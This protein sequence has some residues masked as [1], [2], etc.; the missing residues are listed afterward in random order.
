MNLERLLNRLPKTGAMVAGLLMIVGLGILDYVTGPE[1]TFGIFYV[2]PI[3]LAAWVAGKRGGIFLSV[4]AGAAWLIADVMPGHYS[5]PAIAY[6]NAVARLGFFLAISVL[7]SSLRAKK[8][9]LEAAVS[10]KTASLRAE[11]AEHKHTAEALRESEQRLRLT[12]ESARD[13]AVFRLDSEGRVVGWNAGA[14]RLLGYSENEVVGRPFSVFYS[15]D[16]VDAHRPDRSL[17][18]ARAEGSFEDEGRLVR[19]DGARFWAAVLLTPFETGS[20]KRFSMVV[21]DVTGRKKLE[22]ELLDTAEQERRRIGRDL[23]DVLGQ[24]LTGIAFL[25]KELEDRLASKTLPESAEAATILR[26]VNAAIERT[27]AIS[28]GLAPIE[29]RADGLMNALETLASEAEELFKIPCRFRCPRPVL[30]HDDDTAVHLFRIAQEA[31][32]N[33]VRH[34][35][36]KR[37]R[38]VLTAASGHIVLMVEDDGIG[39]REESVRKESMGLRVMRYRARSIGGTLLIQPGRYSGTLL[40]CSVPAAADRDEGTS[41]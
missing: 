29:L 22:D 24:E 6:W 39:F 11:V 13:Y 40:T 21:H 18:A 4:F 1:I 9:G 38:V 19:K 33:A 25:T 23:H 32:S 26:H 16:D 35:K 28:R 2:V 3:A 30:V 27:R 14:E 10:E 31:V 36:P 37:I 17:A 8:E 41:L 20:M 34:A 5:H 12:I 15:P 7:L